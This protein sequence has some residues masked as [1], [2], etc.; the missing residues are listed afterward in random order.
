VTPPTLRPRSKPD[1]PAL[2]WPGLGLLLAVAS[3]LV[4]LTGGSSALAWHAATWAQRPYTLWTASLAHLSGAHLLANLFGL[5]VMAALG[6][7]LRAGRAALIAV[8][9]AWPLGTAALL[10]WP[11]VAGYQ[12]MSGLLNAMLAILWVQALFHA[13][14]PLSFAI[15]AALAVKLIGEHGWSQP[16]AFDPNWGFNV[17]YAAHFAGAAAGAACGLVTQSIAL[18]RQKYH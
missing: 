18:A 13:A 4:W 8:L 2:A 16:L 12:G 3:A 10:A 9:I 11:Q 1:D 7:Y 17:V 14:K 15:L 5:A 6:L